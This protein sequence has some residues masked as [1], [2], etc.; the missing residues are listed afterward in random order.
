M[1]KTM[2]M[3]MGML[4]FTFALGAKHKPQAEPCQ[5][6]DKA[7]Q[8]M[9]DSLALTTD[10]AAKIKQINADACTKLNAIKSETGE[11][12]SA[13][14]E[15]AKGVMK[16]TKDAYKNVLTAEQLAKLK[17]HKQAKG[18]GNHKKLSAEEKAQKMTVNMT[19]KLTLTGTQISQVQAVNLE[20]CKQRETLHAKKQSGDTVG[21][22]AEHKEIMKGY[23]AKI[24]EILTDEQEL[25][26]KELKKEHRNTKQ[27]NHPKKD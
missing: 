2:G 12:K 15:K 7:Y 11:D 4:L 23:D 9:V 26:W 16:E 22:K 3:M 8:F 5:R 27:Q 21:I 25:K 6:L 24:K 10:Q 14:K 20:L 17:A 18:K 13:Y 19:T 1:K